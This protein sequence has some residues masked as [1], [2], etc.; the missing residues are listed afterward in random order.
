MKPYWFVLA[1]LLVSSTAEAKLSST[2]M[3]RLQVKIIRAESSGNPFAIGPDGERGLMQITKDTWRRYTRVPWRYAF[4][5]T[6]NVE[7]GRKILDRINKF[8]GRRATAARIAY[9]YN[10]GDYLIFNERIPAWAKHHPNRIY[11]R[12]FNAR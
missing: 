8:Y 11:R 1:L 3:D 12:I 6:L 4:D 2:E 7:V 9:S 10:T 5:P